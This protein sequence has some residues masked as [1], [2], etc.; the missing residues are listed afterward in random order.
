MNGQEAD[1]LISTLVPQGCIKLYELWHE[2]VRFVAVEENNK[3]SI[4]DEVDEPYFPDTSDMGNGPL[5][6]RILTKRLLR[7]FLYSARSGTP[8]DLLQR[9]FDRVLHFTYDGPDAQQAASV[10]RILDMIYEQ[11]HFGYRGK[12][13]VDIAWEY[14]SPELFAEFC[15][16]FDDAISVNKVAAV[17]WLFEQGYSHERDVKGLSKELV[18]RILA[19]QAATIQD[20]QSAQ[21]T[22]NTAKRPAK[23]TPAPIIVYRVLWEGREPATVVEAMREEKYI[24]AVIA[25]VLF[26]WCE[27][28][29]KTE[30]GRLLIKDEKESSTYLHHVDK[31]LKKAASLTIVPD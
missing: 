11:R 29:N 14:V 24:D 31:L 7:H 2:A 8:R 9:I 28:T 6:G 10:N 13:K 27:L 4:Y 30:I 19:A 15:G 5:E 22:K 12:D 3:K 16:F 23:P 18:K 1:V 17:I 21:S 25:H 26:H 20:A